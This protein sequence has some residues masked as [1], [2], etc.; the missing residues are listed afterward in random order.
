MRTHGVV[1]R[2]SSCL[3]VFGVL[4]WGLG[5]AS[6]PATAAPGHGAV[7]RTKPVVRK[8]AGKQ[9][10]RYV[11]DVRVAVVSGLAPKPANAINRRL[12]K[13]YPSTP[14]MEK[15]VD[16]MAKGEVYRE[17]VRPQ[18]T[19]NERGLLSVLYSGLGV[20][21]L[22]GKI[23]TAHPTKLVRT[24]TFRLSDGRRLL[25]PDL[26]QKGA[27]WQPFLATRVARFMNGGKGKASPA[28]APPFGPGD[29][30]LTSTALVI[31]YT[32]A[33][34]VIQGTKVVVPYADLKAVANPRGP[35]AP[36]LGSRKP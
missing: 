24:H 15:G 17:D 20:C 19:L 34:F 32:N 6:P 7:V 4:L 9:G 2:A 1:G 12:T 26:F 31:V 3:L 16:T 29:F 14:E 22:K 36:F 33:P 13:G 27:P 25:L 35:L 8:V 23:N 28:D 18:V 5:L 21:T 11:L 10:G 30:Y